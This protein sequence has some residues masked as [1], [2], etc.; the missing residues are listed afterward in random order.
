MI[1]FGESSNTNNLLASFTILS[2][3]SC[4]WIFPKIN[5]GFG[6]FCVHPNFQKCF[7]V[8]SYFHIWLMLSTRLEYSQFTVMSLFITYNRPQWSD[9]GLRALFTRLTESINIHICVHDFY[10]SFCGTEIETKSGNNGH[11]VMA[12]IGEH[13][14]WTQ[15]NTEW[16]VYLMFV[17]RGPK[18]LIISILF[19]F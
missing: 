10:P 6:C 4:T 13:T 1:S 3:H 17:I 5:N 15:L 19:V 9:L 14:K 12:G 7:F 8:C 16:L 11:H 18:I 2:S